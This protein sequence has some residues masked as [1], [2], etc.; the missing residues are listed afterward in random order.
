MFKIGCVHF[1][2]YERADSHESALFA[3]TST[4]ICIVCKNLNIACGAERVK[5]LYKYKFGLYN[6]LA[7]NASC[8]LQFE[9]EKGNIVKKD[10]R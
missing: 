3:K 5:N 9:G 2:I 8:Y 1:S 7:Y 6:S 4:W 10:G